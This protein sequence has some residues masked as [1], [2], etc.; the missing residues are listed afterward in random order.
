MTITGSNLTPRPEIAAYLEQATLFSD[1][2]IGAKVAPPVAVD[3]SSGFYPRFDINQA[4]LL[5]DEVK[6]RAPGT[7]S[8]RIH[9]Q[10]TLDN[11]NT[12]QYSLEAVVPNETSLELGVFNLD[13]ALKESE[14]AQRQNMIAHERR[15]ATKAFNPS[16]FAI[17]TS[18][19]AYT[20][21]N[22][23]STGFDVGLDVD[24]AKAEIRKRGERSDAAALIAVMSESVY[25]RARASERL[26]R[27]IRGS[28]VASDTTLILSETELAAAL[29]VREVLVGRASVDVSK[30]KAS[31]SSLSDI[32]SNTYLWVGH[33]SAPS[34]ANGSFLN[35]SALAT[36]FWRQPTGSLISAESYQEEKID[37]EVIRARMFTDEKVIDA[38]RGQLIV[39][40]FS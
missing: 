16:T 34:A 2:F 37:S 27:R 35:G 17:I 24:L 23:G 39:T 33:A 25:I 13:L 5:R 38:N 36:L 32:W 29:G 15:V 22:I 10:H 28:A 40:Q 11:Y 31:A 1:L 9:R 7:E 14:F 19:T 30:Q 8:A 20:L 18:G 4:N 6:A 3:R 26:I 12:Q 21:A